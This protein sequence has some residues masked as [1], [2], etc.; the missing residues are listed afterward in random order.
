MDDSRLIIAVDFGTTYSGIAY[1]FANQ[2]NSSPIPI[3]NWPGATG[4]DVPKTPTVICYDKQN[5]RNFVWGGSVE[6]QA[7]SISDFKLLLDPSQKWPE[8]I[9]IINIT[10]KL[11]E[12]PKSPTRIT[13]DFIGAIH[14][15]AIEEISK[16][17]PRDYVQLCRKEYIFSVP[18]VWSDAAKYATL[19]AAQLA[20]LTSVQLIKEPEAA[21]LWITKK[22]NIA[23]KSGDIFVVCDA[24]GGTVDLV[25][26][27]VENTSPQLR[28]K[29]VVPGTGGMAGSLNLN[30]RFECAVKKLVGEKQWSALHSSKGFQ[31]AASQFEKEIKKEFHGGCDDDCFDDEFYVNFYPAKLT[32]NPNCGLESNTWTMV[33]DDLMDIFNPVIGDVLRLIDEQVERVKVKMGGGPKYIFLVGGFGSNR[34]LMKRIMNRYSN[35]EVLQPPDA[36]AAIAKGAALSRMSSKAT[37]TSLSATRHYGIG[38]SSIYDE[39]EDHGRP[40]REA[41]TGRIMMWYIHTG[42]N[43]LKSARI[44][45]AVLRHFT[46][47]EY[48]TKAFRLSCPLFESQEET[49]PRYPSENETFRVNCEL[50]YSL[51]KVPKHLFKKHISEFYTVALNLIMTLEGALVTFSSEID[52]VLYDCVEAKYSP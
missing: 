52:G 40:F 35:I 37:V 27:E 38:V 46:Q 21:V 48:E 42:D 15:H 33:E 50:M 25:S 34:Y 1:C 19:K 5:P 47:H 23:L 20:G 41:I 8:Y 28:V 12:L 7:D 39:I 3:D 32:D 9:P 6:P 18:A 22:L 14:N 13:A 29:E 51:S 36:W 11:E 16:K 17:F 49:A 2:R 44:P 31:R 43:L 30:K 24:G 4:I 26:Y 10:K 45:F